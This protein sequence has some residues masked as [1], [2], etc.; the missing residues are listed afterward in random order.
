MLTRLASPFSEAVSPVK[1]PLVRL[2]CVLLQ[3]SSFECF[4]PAALTTDLF[5]TDWP[6]SLLSPTFA[7]LRRHRDCDVRTVLLGCNSSISTKRVTCSFALFKRWLCLKP[8]QT[9]SHFFFV[10]ALYKISGQTLPIV[11]IEKQLVPL[12]LKKNSFYAA[13]AIMR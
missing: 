6:L 13:Q 1:S 11:R 4:C 8:P 3:L 7:L 2:S 12:Q 9:E 10:S 5:L